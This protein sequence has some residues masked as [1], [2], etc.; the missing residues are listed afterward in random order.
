VKREF[1]EYHLD[2]LLRQAEL[3]KPFMLIA[4]KIYPA[5]NQRLRENGI[6]YLDTAGNIYASNGNL[7]LWLDGQSG[8]IVI[9]I[10]KQTEPSQKL[11]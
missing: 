3:N 11:D 8:C 1:H 7:L 4:D 5:Q 2:K 6:A 10:K 9:M